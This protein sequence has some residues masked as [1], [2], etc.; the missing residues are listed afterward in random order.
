MLTFGGVWIAYC[1]CFCG[2]AFIV[3]LSDVLWFVGLFWCLAVVACYCIWFLVP[4]V[5]WCLFVGFWGLLI[6]M[7]CGCLIVLL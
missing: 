3:L 1:V 7:L 4:V 2:V 5:A 6:S